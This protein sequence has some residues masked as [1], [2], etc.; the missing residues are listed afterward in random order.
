MSSPFA[1][2]YRKR[3]RLVAQ[4]KDEVKRMFLSI[5]ENSDFEMEVRETRAKTTFISLFATFLA[6][7][8]RGLFPWLKQEGTRHR[9]QFDSIW[10]CKQY[11]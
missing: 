7:P 10:L 11:W 2:K 5:A 9:W 8:L 4:L 1:S 6:C 3:G